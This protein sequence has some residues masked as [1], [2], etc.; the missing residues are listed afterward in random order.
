MAYYD[1]FPHNWI[2]GLI[3]TTY[4]STQINTSQDRL[5]E[6]RRILLGAPRRRLEVH[7]SGMDQATGANL[8]FELMRS[9]FESRRIPIYQDVAVTTASS[10]GTTINCPT[11][12][13]R[14]YDDQLVLITDP[15]GTTFEFATISSFTASAITTS[16]A[17][18]NSYAAG[19]VVFP[20]MTSEIALEAGFLGVTDHV[21]ELLAGFI[22]DEPSLP[23]S[24]DYSDLAGLGF[25]QINSFAYLLDIEPNWRSSVQMAMRRVGGTVAFPRRTMPNPRG[26]RGLLGMRLNFGF[27]T[28]A[29]FFSFLQFF[30]AHRGRAHPFWVACPLTLW[31]PSAVSTA[32]LDVTQVGD[33]T[34]YTNFVQS[35]S[36]GSPFLYIKKVDGTKVLAQITGTTAPGGGV[37]R[38]AA[39]LPSMNLADISRVSLAFLVRFD[40]DALEESWFTNEV[41]EVSVPVVELLRWEDETATAGNDGFFSGGVAELCD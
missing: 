32:Y 11:T 3:M 25:Q 13:R 9:G 37:F 2:T 18:S 26:P 16:G 22:E 6:T 10:S 29:E 17:L 4:W 19:S 33:L 36:G 39:T 35:I 1:Y 31:E 12:Y 40:S 7:W 5:A 41:V 30:D 15:E 20:V 28:R 34:D 23:A 14:F 21:G 38:L 27:S 24:A 8:M